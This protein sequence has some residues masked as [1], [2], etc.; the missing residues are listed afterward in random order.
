MATFNSEA[1]NGGVILRPTGPGI[2]TFSS[3]VQ[4][5]AGTAIAAGDTFNFFTIAPNTM[6]HAVD[7]NASEF[8]DASTDCTFKLGYNGALDFVVAAST[9]LRA[10]G[11]IRYASEGSYGTVFAGNSG[12]GYVPSTSANRVISA[13]IVAAPTTQTTADNSVRYITIHGTFSNSTVASPSTSFTLPRV[14]NTST[15]QAS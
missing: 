2:Y 14:T 12:N 3:T 4:V 6:W 1:Y 7:I 8:E 5:P 11:Q 15:Q 9:L 13:T 10:G